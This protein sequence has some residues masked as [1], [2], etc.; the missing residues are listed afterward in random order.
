M[1]ATFA[2]LIGT[3]GL[4]PAF[5]DNPPYKDLYWFNNAGDPEI[6]YLESE[7]DNLTVDNNGT[8][9][10]QDVE[11]ETDDARSAINSAVSGLTIAAEDNS[12]GYNYIEVGAKS[13]NW[14]V[15]AQAQTVAYYPT[16]NLYQYAESELDFATGYEWEVESNDC[17]IWNDKDIEWLANHELGHAL[18][19]GHHTGSD[20]S[21]MKNGCTS[22]YQAVQSVDDA[23]LEVRY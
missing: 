3:I 20:H 12:C 16:P 19:L 22:K 15:M 21:M 9:H 7:L 2:V 23:A 4:T 5:A 6:C 11:D 14:G 18:S 1:T 8:G 10:G 13:L 17:G